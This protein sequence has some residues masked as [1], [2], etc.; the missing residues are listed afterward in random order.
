[1]KISQ[2]AAIASSIGTTAGLFTSIYSASKFFTKNPRVSLIAWGALGVIGVGSAVSF[3]S[4]LK[5]CTPK[6]TLPEYSLLTLTEATNLISET[7][8]KVLPS[9]QQEVVTTSLD[10]LNA[11]AK[12]ILNP[13]KNS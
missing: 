1:M 11:K 2:E 6:S 13:P 3:Y 7:T 5:H 8:S 9:N 12:D 10:K 4:A